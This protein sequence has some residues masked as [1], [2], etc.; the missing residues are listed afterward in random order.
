MKSL[1][2][3][4]LL[5]LAGLLLQSSACKKKTDDQPEE[6]ITCTPANTA[7]IPSDARSRFFFREGSWW[8]Y[9]NVGNEELDTV[10]VIQSSL[11]T[12]KP[13][14]ELWGDIPNK[15]YERSIVMFQPQKHFR[16]TTRVEFAKAKQEIDSSNE[17]YQIIDDYTFDAS[18]RVSYKFVYKGSTI[19]P[20]QDSGFIAHID[21]MQIAAKMYY[22][23]LYYETQNLSDYITSIY[24]A[25]GVGTIKMRR[26]DGTTWELVNSKTIQ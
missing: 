21:S 22:D 18:A 11:P 15:C 17:I 6:K 19:Y 20:N 7:Y 25:A 14:P 9:K 12:G 3:I 23:I 24:Y 5:F 26:T 1:F 10:K 8:V 2:N 4:T 13:I 16:Y